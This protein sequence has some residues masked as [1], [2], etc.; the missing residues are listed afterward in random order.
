MFEA[1]EGWFKVY[2]KITEWE[3]H[4]VPE[5]VSLFIHLLAMA[6]IE[7]KKWHGIVIKRGELVTSRSKLSATTGI[8]ER[9]IRTCLERLTN[10]GCVEI[11]TATKQ[12]TK[13]RICKYELYQENKSQTDQRV[14]NER[15]T[16]DQR[17]TITKEYKKERRYIDDGNVGDKFF[18]DLFIEQIMRRAAEYGIDIAPGD[19]RQAVCDILDYWDATD[20]ENRTPKHLIGVYTIKLKEHKD[21][22][23][24]DSQVKPSKQ[25]WREQMAASAARDMIELQKLF[26]N[27]SKE[28]QN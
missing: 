2:R 28:Q 4:D 17:L 23:R 13:V 19:A 20:E 22:R 11:S 7:D 25:Q 24:K 10:S 15:P 18:N 26:D 12:F 8:S 3:W 21:Q 1:M 16:T 27:A 14:T 5:M 6:N 9:T